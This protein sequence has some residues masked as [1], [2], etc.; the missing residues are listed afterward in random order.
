MFEKVEDMVHSFR[1]S[2]PLIQQLVC[3]KKQQ[4][5]IESQPTDTT[6]TYFV[7]LRDELLWNHWSGKEVGL[8]CSSAV[9]LQFTKAV[10]LAVAAAA[11]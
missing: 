5:Q 7:L 6:A 1:I 9:S 11:A 10:S 8:Q 2:S 3:S 4:Q